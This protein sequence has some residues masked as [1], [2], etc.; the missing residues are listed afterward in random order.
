[1]AKKL[2]PE[3]TF[4]EETSELS[5]A[6][7]TSNGDLL[8]EDDDGLLKRLPIESIKSMV[9]GVKGFLKIADVKPTVVGKY[10]LVEIGTYSNLTPSAEP[11]VTEDGYYNSAYWDGTNWTLSKL[12]LPSNTAFIE[13]F[14][15]SVFPLSG[16]IQRTYDGK[17]WQLK[18]GEIATF[19]DV[20][21]VSE[22][23]QL[24]SI[25]AI[26]NAEIKTLNQFSIRP[27]ISDQDI[28]FSITDKENVMSWLSA[29]KQGGMPDFIK[30]YVAAEVKDKI[31]E[32][33]FQ[34]QILFSILDQSDNLSWLSI[35][36]DGGMPDFVQDYI[37]SNIISRYE[38]TTRSK[39]NVIYCVG[40]SITEGGSPGSPYPTH[41]QAL[42]GSSKTVI[43]EGH[44][45]RESAD[46]AVW[47]GGLTPVLK[48]SLNVPTSGE[49][50]IAERPIDI[51]IGKFKGF[52][53]P[54]KLGSVRGTLKLNDDE[55]TFSFIRE[56]SGTAVTLPTGTQFIADGLQKLDNVMVWW[57]GQNDL[58]FGWPYVYTAPRDC[59]L[60]VI[61]KMPVDI[62]RF[63]II[64]VT[65]GT[66][67]FKEDSRLQNEVLREAFPNNFVDMQDVLVNKGLTMAG[68]TPT[69]TDLNAIADYRIP[70]SL[71]Y[72]FVHPNEVCK[73]KVIA[74]TIYNELA[75]RD[76]L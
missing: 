36:K 29:D 16:D 54:G 76:W 71:L 73:Q 20:P 44:S 5:V 70:P 55:N 56:A 23:W 49:V 74:P 11:I 8:L 15:D 32:K 42:L 72:D 30:N 41:L 19:S 58:A 60:A 17:T 64:G 62:K 26:E 69:S 6:E 34:D 33:K 10:D 46:L 27:A 63:L 12:E 31:F 75:K 66:T 47:T 43:N 51:T 50:F 2:N 37:F 25:G 22:K 40:D 38:A 4:V 35:G 57:T 45:G 59:A 21:G 52:T 7:I 14:E 1:M 67:N 9:Q 61:A 48:A 13:S 68:I 18:D 53:V 3:F 24:L 65:N 39:K 28:S